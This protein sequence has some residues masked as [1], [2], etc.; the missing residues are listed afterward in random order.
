M[1]AIAASIGID[2]DAASTRPRRA[3]RAPSWSTRCSAP[4]RAAPRAAPC[5]AAVEWIAAHTGPVV[6]LDVPSG[7][8]A[9]TGR[10]EGAAVRAD[11]TVTF[12][13]DMVGLRVDPGPRARRA[14][15]GGRHRHPVGRRAARRRR[16]SPGA[17]AIAAVP[18]QGRR[19]PTSTPRARCW[20]WPARRGSPAP[21]ASRRAP[22]CAPARASP[23]SRRPRG[24]SRGGRGAAAGGDVRAAARRGRA[25]GAR[26]RSSA[27]WP[28]PGR[29]SAVALGPGPRP[30]RG[31][32]RGR[33][34]ADRPRRPARWSST[35]TASGT[36]ATPPS[37]LAGRAARRPSSRPTP[38]EAARLL[39]R[40][41]AEVEA[42][43]LASRARAGASARG[44]SWC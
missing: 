27:C 4:A 21:P 39:G 37:A 34:R 32:D 19:P 30:R 36:W 1:T 22:P 3:R 9:D 8:E 31:H 17:G 35:R 5:G 43:R 11:L 40:A 10:V 33:P 26:R 7:V 18:R 28:R 25:P 24:S 12:H 15:R 23:W 20:W 29:A 6:A 44:P 42:D 2:V 38:G 16:G 13:G 41:R 14:R